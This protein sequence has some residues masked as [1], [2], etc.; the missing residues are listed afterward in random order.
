MRLNKLAI[1][2]FSKICHSE[3][4]LNCRSQQS[5]IK[6]NARNIRKLGRNHDCRVVM[7]NYVCMY[8]KKTLI[9]YISNDKNLFCYTFMHRW[10]YYYVNLVVIFFGK[11]FHLRLVSFISN[12]LIFSLS[13]FIIIYHLFLIKAN[14]F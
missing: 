4:T 5:C 12:L 9:Y 1:K 7:T 8:V 2:S 3:S 11:V 6:I 10:G 13:A 14:W